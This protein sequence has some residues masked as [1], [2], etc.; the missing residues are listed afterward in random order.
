M[1]AEAEGEAK[2]LALT[3]VSR[4]EQAT[5]CPLFGFVRKISDDEPGGGHKLHY[6]SLYQQKFVNRRLTVVRPEVLTVMF[7]T[8]APCSGG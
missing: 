3:P 6:K 7:C 1:H 8:V 4:T 5:L 2:L